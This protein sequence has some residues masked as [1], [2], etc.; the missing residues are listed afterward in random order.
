MQAHRQAGSYMVASMSDFIHHPTNCMRCGE[1]RHGYDGIVCVRGQA[2]VAC[3]RCVRGQLPILRPEIIEGQ[4]FDWEFGA[5]AAAMAVDDDGEVNW[6]AAFYADPGTMTCPGCLRKLWR[7]GTL[8]RCPDC[9]HEWNTN[10]PSERG[11]HHGQT[12][13]ATET[14][15]HPPLGAD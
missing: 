8:V 4:P 9:Q 5:K 14:D 6:R 2:Q 10:R 12:K 7:E 1:P 11:H 3:R 15:C 13:E